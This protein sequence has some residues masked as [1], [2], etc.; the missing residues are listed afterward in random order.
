MQQIQN[1]LILFALP[2]MRQCCHECRTG[3]TRK[4]VE[5]MRNAMMERKHTK[6]VTIERKHVL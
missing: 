5:S 1:E 4:G 6:T 3:M 2:M